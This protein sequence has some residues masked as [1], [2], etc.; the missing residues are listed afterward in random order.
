MKKL[1]T[2][3]AAALLTSAGAFAQT[4]T[5]TEW[6]F[7]DTDL[8]GATEK[9]GDAIDVTNGQ[10]TAGLTLLSPASK[11]MQI[12]YSKK[13]VDGV[14][15][16]QRLKTQGTSKLKNYDT[17]TAE[18]C[19]IFEVTG[20]CSISVVAVSGKTDATDRNLKIDAVADGTGTNLG[21]W[22]LPGDA[23]VTNTATY[24]GGATT[25]WIY[26]GN[27]N[28]N[29]YDIKVTYGTAT[30]ISAVQ[31]NATKTDNATYNLAGQKVGS[32]YKGIVVKDGKKYI[33][34]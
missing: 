2:L 1:C 34:K 10:V 13:T 9:G 18:R 17:S 21:D 28:I 6:N 30:G 31:P 8:W 32:D 33:N 22:I 16:T 7:S 25:I 14:T 19:M 11:P 5:V 27:S 3:I 15:Y 20:D 26:S 24:K 4:S 12:D 29:I 23:P